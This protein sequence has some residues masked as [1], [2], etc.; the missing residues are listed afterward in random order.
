MLK[1]IL[2]VFFVLV[3]SGLSLFLYFAD[4]FSFLSPVK[5][6]N[7]RIEVRNDLGGKGEFF[8]S[9]NGHR[10]HEGIDLSAPIGT[11]VY[12][13]RL[14]K[15][16]LARSIRNQNTKTGSG[17]YI[18]VRHLDGLVSVYAHLS[19]IRV[20]PGQIVRQGQMIGRVGKT[21]NANYANIQPH[22]HFEVRKNRLP[23][24]PSEFLETRENY[25]YVLDPFFFRCSLTPLF[26][27]LFQIAEKS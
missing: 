26:D 22:L 1:K 15:V 3:L 12:S 10:R 5:Y 11:P 7:G 13:V 6:E 17:N 25:Q 16:V 8:A 19:E 2:I 21:G 20:R 24:D 18:I 23:L 9:R 14:G 4:K 27:Y